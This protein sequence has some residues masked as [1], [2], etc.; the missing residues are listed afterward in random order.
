MQTLKHILY[1]ADGEF[2]PTRAFRRAV[3]LAERHQAKLTL[4][5]VTVESGITAELV[6]RFGLA[7]DVQQS[8]QRLAALTHLAE[9]WVSGQLPQLRV[10]IGTPF[11]EVIRAVLRGGHDLVL[12]PVRP[13]PG[14]HGLFASTEM[15]L[16]RKC[17]CPVWIDREPPT[18]DAADDPPRCRGVLAAVDAAQPQSTALNREILDTAAA[19]AAQDGAALD[20][21][22]VWQAP[23][24]GLPKGDRGAPSGARDA[25]LGDAVRLIEHQH[26]A[27]LKSLA[28]DYRERMAD[29][30]LHLVRG[31]PAEQVLA[32]AQALE[33]D[34][35]VLATLSRP[36]EPGL[37]IGT[38]AEDLLRGA[39]GSVL[40]LK[41][42]GFV[43]PVQ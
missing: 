15:H 8:E 25:Q 27:A 7:D 20:V 12:K 21:V 2:V 4:M 38:T 11:I 29:G 13:R 42:A 32:R 10:T 31:T 33:S 23:F 6:K 34:L 1:F 28:A 19:V 22:H 9:T 26:A 43:S 14:C 41:P 30:N 39:Q 40:A 37:F 5:D 16:L 17:P 18:P 24:D 35:I 36:R 3:A